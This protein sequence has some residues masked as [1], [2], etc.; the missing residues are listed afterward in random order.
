MKDRFQEFTSDSQLMQEFFQIQQEENQSVTSFYETVIRKYRKAR[1]FITEQQVITVL[2]TGVKNSLKEHLI[3]NE[4]D[5][6]KPDEWLQFAREEE[7]IQKRIQQQ[8]NGFYSETTKQ[9]F[10]ESML[11]TATVQPRPSNIQSSSQQPFT[12]RHYYEKQN[13]QPYKLA[14]NKTFKNSNHYQN[15]KQNQ[16]IHLE[17]KIQQPD[18]CLICNRKNHLTAKCFYKKDNGCFKCGQ[19]DHQLRDCPKRHFFE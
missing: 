3:R 1:R 7:Y 17:K 4:K 2:Q 15:K 5:I 12:S 16:E 9:P 14:Q 10:F 19:S 13:Q 6:T 18:S 11:S 8:R